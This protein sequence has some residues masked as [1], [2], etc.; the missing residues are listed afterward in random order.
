M[1]I[2][3]V[4]FTPVGFS[5]GYDMDEVDAFL[6]RIA[7]AAGPGGAGVTTQLCDEVEHVRFTPVRMVGGYD[8]DEVDT[9]VDSVITT[10]LRELAAV[11]GSTAGRCAYAEQVPEQPPLARGRLGARYDVPAIEA[12]RTDVLAALRGPGGDD[13]RCRRAL[14]I[15]QAARPPRVTGLGVGCLVSDVEARRERV[16]RVLGGS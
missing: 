14:G 3:A 2:A 4:R 8:M 10:A 5:E 15:L 6:D 13:D 16:V 11:S 12:L 7:Q 9:F 1:R